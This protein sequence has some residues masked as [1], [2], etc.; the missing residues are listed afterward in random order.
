M[1]IAIVEIGGGVDVDVAHAVEMLDHRH[2]RLARD[3]LDQALAAARHDDVDV[4]VVGDQ[5]PD[6]RAVGRR[7][8]L[9]RV[10]GQSGGAQAACTHA[11]IAW[12]LRIASEP[13]RRIVALPA[14]RHRPAASAVTFG[15]DS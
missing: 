4:L 8:D 15:R 5:V 12:L 10:L 9:H 6:R 1:R 11:A 13:P 14:L 3:A 7:D 2:L